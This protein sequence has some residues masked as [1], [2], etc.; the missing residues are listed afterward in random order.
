MLRD[1][2]DLR[3]KKTVV[4]LA[5]QLQAKGAVNVLVS[6]AGDGAVLVAEDGSVH[7]ADEGEGIK[8]PKW[9]WFKGYI[10]YVLPA[11]IIFTFCLGI[12][13]LFFK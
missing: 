10:K 2:D 8:L 7:E 1:I 11:I 9:R 13:N 5:R 4:E 12:Y 3:D 6:M